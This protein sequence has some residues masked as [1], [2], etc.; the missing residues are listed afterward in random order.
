M[1]VHTARFADRIG[2]MFEVDGLP[3]IAGRIMGL[4]L[5]RDEACSLDEVARELRV[6][7]AS[8]STN[9]RLLA[10]QGVLERTSREG[11]RRDYYQ[12]VPDLF[13]RMM[14]QR[15]GRWKRFAEAV[16]DVRRAVPRRSLAV[17]RRLAEYEMAWTY[18]SGAIE[19][20]LEHRPARRPR[21]HAAVS[22]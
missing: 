13:P 12:V 11:D 9:A 16:G 4:L 7:K 1:D 14:A 21:A 17:R 6:S 22:R 8:V 3:P 15:L 19:Q 5:L 2:R 20:A 10:D 18:M